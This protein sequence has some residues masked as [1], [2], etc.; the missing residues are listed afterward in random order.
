MSLLRPLGWRLALPLLLLLMGCPGEVPC[1]VANLPVR[2]P[3]FMLVGEP[4]RLSI[5]PQI[6]GECDGPMNVPPRSLTVEILDPDQQPVAHQATLGN[7]TSA[8]ATL[9]FTPTRPGPHHVFA[10]FDP[11]G[12]IHQFDIH[13]AHDR[14]RQAPI[15]QLNS[16]CQVLERTARGTWIC[17][18][19]VFRD[20]ALVE[21][22]PQGRLAVAGD[23]VWV[24]GAQQLHRF[25]DTGGPLLVPSASL[26]HRMGLPEF[27]LAS[28]DEL[29]VL[30][31][32][33][34]QRVTFSGTTLTPTGSTSWGPGVQEPISPTSPRG[35]LLRAGDRLALVRRPSLNVGT[36]LEA[37]AYQLQ[38]GAFARTS[39][40]CQQLPGVVIGFEPGVLWL[41]EQSAGPTL[42]AIHRLEWTGTG[43]VLRGSLGMTGFQPLFPLMLARSSAVPVLQSAHA[44]PPGIVTAVPLHVPGE[45]LLQLEHLDAEIRD[46]LASSSFFWGARPTAQGT[47]RVRGR[48]STP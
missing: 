7:P 45:E 11:V 6:P 16:A 1:F 19:A 40:A 32:G 46:P 39:D 41:G 29:V 4:T 30:Y 17:N 15:T 10:A 2:Q 44:L 22:L 20:G 12:G 38:A 47:T 24:V 43:F 3:A 14:S 28:A 13:A 26:E 36:P 48:P 21:Q 31:G 27:L 33:T 42:S 35:V 8:H 25:V 34:L 18:A 9:L 5:A 23:V 37:C